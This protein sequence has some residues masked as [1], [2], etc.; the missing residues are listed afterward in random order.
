MSTYS[1]PIDDMRFVVKEL[2]GL[3][4]I[5]QLPG[6]EEATADLVDAVLD[7][8]GR[9]SSGVLDPLNQSGDKFGAE[10]KANANY[11]FSVIEEQS[12]GLLGQC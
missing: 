8:A 7:E 10:L 12:S 9:F 1:A 2:V 11:G 5:S 6:C 4:E 3:E